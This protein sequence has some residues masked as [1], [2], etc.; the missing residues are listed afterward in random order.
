MSVP[1]E[2]SWPDPQPVRGLP[3]MFDGC[4]VTSTWCAGCRR[5]GAPAI[6]LVRLVAGLFLCLRCDSGTGTPLPSWAAVPGGSA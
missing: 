1:G 6:R 5:R 4:T 2:A 3:P